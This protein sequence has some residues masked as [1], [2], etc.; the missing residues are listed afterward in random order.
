MNVGQIL[1]TAG[2]QHY[3]A[4][5]V[6]AL[7]ALTVLYTFMPGRYIAIGNELVEN[8][9]FSDGAK[10]WSAHGPITLQYDTATIR[11]DGAGPDRY[12]VIG[13][14]VAS[15]TA[16]TATPSVAKTDGQA[17]TSDI[18]NINHVRVTVRVRTN[19]LSTENHLWPAAGIAVHT[20]ALNGQRLWY[21]PWRVIDFAHDTDWHTRSAIVA[22]APNAQSPWFFAFVVSASGFAEIDSFSIVPVRPT[23]VGRILGLALIGAWALFALLVWW[24]F[25]G[26]GPRRLLRLA[27]LVV[28]TVMVT[29]GVVP[30]PHLANVV[31]GAVAM[32]ASATNALRERA[33]ILVDAI[34]DSADT[35]DPA[36][37]PVGDGVAGLQTPRGTDGSGARDA[38]ESQPPDGPPTPS[39]TTG[40]DQAEGES[41]K[42]Q[43]VAP[44][45][46]PPP[47]KSIKDG[48][49]HALAFFALTAMALLAFG[50]HPAPTGRTR[51][52]P[53]PTDSLSLNASSLNRLNLAPWSLGPWM[54]GPWMLGTLRI[55]LAL[56]FLSLT[57]QTLQRL[58]VTREADFGDMAYDFG[59][60]GLGLVLWLTAMAL[61]R[62]P[63]RDAE[64]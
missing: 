60:I 41:D 51:T 16:L 21:W 45:G 36:L 23:A 22:L 48:W 15:L 9:D 50:H 28:G 54:L 19:G 37:A 17:E 13:R 56:V 59:G 26:P 11:L 8:H 47:V 10:H 24:R 5:I 29:A 31:N 14:S 38:D 32:M 3:L 1:A 63:I 42:E 18:T 12:V 7:I 25:A 53:S 52:G 4:M 43:E 57:I 39:D 20:H 6:M 34:S 55:G 40:E 27:T 64:T 30:Q 33:L 44:Q 2:K 62:A 61:R 58:S 49:G 46:V 35:A